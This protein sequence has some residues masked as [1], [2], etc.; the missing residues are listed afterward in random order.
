MVIY[1]FSSPIIMNN[2]IFTEYGGKLGSFT[3]AQI[4]NSFRLAE[5]QVSK[6]AGTLLLPQVVT[7]TYGFQQNYRLVTDYGYVSRII[8]VNVLSKKDFL[9]ADLQANDGVAYIWDDTYGS[10]DF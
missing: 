8:A 4:T 10:I 7:G 6:Y 3:N 1:P 5:M 2:S 9:T